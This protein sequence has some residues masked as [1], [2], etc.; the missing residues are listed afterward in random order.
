MPFCGA[1]KAFFEPKSVKVRALSAQGRVYAK[2]RFMSTRDKRL[3]VKPVDVARAERP[4]LSPLLQSCVQ[5]V[6]D[7]R[8]FF[9]NDSVCTHGARNGV[10]RAIRGC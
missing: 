1:K 4:R 8:A 7:Q 5:P 2:S 3:T 10:L 6:L 9:R